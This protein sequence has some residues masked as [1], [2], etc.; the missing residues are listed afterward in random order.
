MDTTSTIALFGRLIF[1]LAIVIGLMW[2]AANVL[3]KRGLAGTPKKRGGPPVEVELLAR[4][5]L[6]RNTSISVVRVGDRAMVIGVTDHQV[7]NLGDVDLDQIDLMEAGATWTSPAGALGPGR[8]AP[9]SP[10]TAWKAML[11]QMRNKTARR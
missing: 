7:T 4:K 2:V 5:P 11:E 9:V 8:P 1:S 10:N 3:R 6:G